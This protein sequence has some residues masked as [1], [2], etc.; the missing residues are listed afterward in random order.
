VFLCDVDLCVSL[1]A[2][3]RGKA[4]DRNYRSQSYAIFRHLTYAS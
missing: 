4:D 2:T 3:Q 1:D